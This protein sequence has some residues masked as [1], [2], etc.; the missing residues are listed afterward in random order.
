MS[1]NSYMG[2]RDPQCKPKIYVAK[3]KTHGHI[4]HLDLELSDRSRDRLEIGYHWQIALGVG[5]L[6]KARYMG[7]I[8]I[9]SEDCHTCHRHVQ[10][11]L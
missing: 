10:G 5:E 4:Y 7:V 3:N 6:T 1:Q 8:G 2:V 9:T 11:S